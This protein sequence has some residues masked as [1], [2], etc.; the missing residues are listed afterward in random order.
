LQV[1]FRGDYW[2]R[3][4]AILSKEEER[5]N[6]MKGSKSLKV[7]AIEVFNNFCWNIRSRIKN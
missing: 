7:I 3:S 1:I 2:V 5:L 4:W 6:L